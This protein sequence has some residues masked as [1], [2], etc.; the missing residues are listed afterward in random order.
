M[1]LEAVLQ[2]IEEGKN[3]FIKRAKELSEQQQAFNKRVAEALNISELGNSS[4]DKEGND[5]ILK[6]N[7]GGRNMD[8]KRSI[9]TKS[10][11]GWNLFSCLFEKREG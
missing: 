9:L 7:F 2:Q 1:N 8:I 11:F 5:D 6:I 10:N 4:T 3:V